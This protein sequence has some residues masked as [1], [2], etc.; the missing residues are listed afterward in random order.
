MPF[1]IQRPARLGGWMG[2]G[3]TRVGYLT[4]LKPRYFAQKTSWDETSKTDPH[5]LESEGPGPPLPDT[6]S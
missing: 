1:L 2:A 5:S 6:A 3:K 4:P